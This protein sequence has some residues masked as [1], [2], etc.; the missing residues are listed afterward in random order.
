VAFQQLQIFGRSFVD[1]D[2]DIAGALTGYRFIYPA[3]IAF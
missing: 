3:D 2:A 1:G